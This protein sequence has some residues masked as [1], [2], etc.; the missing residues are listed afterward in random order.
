M[1]EDARPD[2]PVPADPAAVAALIQGR[3]N[4]LIGPDLKPVSLSLDFG[5]ACGVAGRG[6]L[7]AEVDRRTRTLAFARARLTAPDGRLI[8]TGSGVFSRPAG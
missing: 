7:V 2:L 8:A 6:T 4:D 1:S 5:P 3:L